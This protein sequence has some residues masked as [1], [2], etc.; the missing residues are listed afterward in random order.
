MNE[1]NSVDASNPNFW[2]SWK[3]L[4]I[5]LTAVTFLTVFYAAA[6]NYVIPNRQ[7]AGTF[8]DSFG[9]L[10]SLF[11]ALA[12][13]GLIF[14]LFVQKQELSLQRR[15]FESLVIEQEKSNKILE[16][17]SNSIYRQNF[18]NTFFNLLGEFRAIRDGISYHP[19]KGSSFYGKEAVEKMS[20]ALFSRIDRTSSKDFQEEYAEFYSENENN[21]GPYLRL[22]F[23]ITSFIDTSEIVDKKF[24]TN[25]L[26]AQLSSNESQIFMMNGASSHGK[27]KFLPLIKKYN[28]LKYYSAPSRFNSV[29]TLYFAE[30]YKGSSFLDNVT[31]G[32]S[33]DIQAGA[34]HGPDG[35]DAS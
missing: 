21:I 25:I 33:K 6:I 14:T 28:L 12:F 2:V 13:A 32:P 17:Q 29:A 22:F 16:N 9:A 26:R 1:N 10:T 15:E 30:I 3:S 7:D 11:T 35:R 5:L 23:H 19:F 34:A 27:E 31:I 8:G 18:E 24:Y 4:C 20:G